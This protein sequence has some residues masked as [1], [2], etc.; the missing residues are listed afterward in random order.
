MKL[1][2]KVH[3]LVVVSLLTA[4]SNSDDSRSV[5][6]LDDRLSSVIQS[7]ALTGD[8]SAGRDL[9]SINEPIAQLGMKLFYSK[10]LGG[11]QDAACVSCHHP[12]LGGGDDLSLP[13]GVGADVHDLLGPG[14]THGGGDVEPTVPRNAPTTFNIALW[15]EVLFHDGRVESLGKTAG[16]N[17]ADG[18]G[19]RT[20][21]SAFGSSD[22]E[23]GPSLTA[24]Q[25]RF[26]VTS[27]AE[28][29][30]DYEL[31]GTNAQ[32]RARLQARL[33]DEAPS[34]GEIDVDGAD[35]DGL[36][37][38]VSAFEEV[39]AATVPSADIITFDRVT[40]AI[41]AYEISQVFVDTPWKS[42]VEGNKSALSDSQKRGAL[43]FFTSIADGGAGCSS[44]HSGDFF[45]D[46]AF[47]NLAMP[48][49]GEGKG[50]GVSGR[51]DFGR[52]RETSLVSDQYAFRTPTLLNI[53]HTGPYGHSGAYETLEDVIRHHLNPSDAIDDYFAAGGQ[54]SNLS[55]LEG[56]SCEDISGDVAES[57]TRL[58]LDKLE[59]D[60]TAGLSSLIE[61][62][63]SDQTV[64]DL[65]SF[66]TALTDPCLED[67]MCLSQWIPESSDNTIDG[68]Q[69]NGEDENASPLVVN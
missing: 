45:T 52:M 31:G 3:G 44:C 35:E 29:R 6:S 25:A 36:N 67:A 26:P 55:Q 17:G 13:I 40:E 4:C 42:Y 57:N 8:P 10:S 46:E 51:D 37:N 22:P 63:L 27:A 2:Y 15:D 19:I 34:A 47:H 5:S 69:I 64:M 53:E 56:A 62:E 65:V 12:A 33:R 59:T 49:I 18:I 58:A 38:W 43:V 11:D 50:N 61:T 20:P 28:M 16:K 23:A 9:V 24:A 14:R 21:D 54:C 39:Y 7:N 41:A 66:M 68:N 30:S 1:A 32:L 60:M 48:Q